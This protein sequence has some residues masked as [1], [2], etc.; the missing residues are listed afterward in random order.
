MRN[1]LLICFLLFLTL[2]FSQSE[3]EVINQIDSIN[4]AALNFYNVNDIMHSIDSF[5]EAIKLSDSINDSY[6]NAVANFTLGKIY[7][8]MEEYNDAESC[9]K[10][11]LAESQ[12][13]DD[14]F[15]IA[16][17]YLSLGEVYRNKQQISNV[18]PYFKNALLYA[19]KDIVTDQNNIDERHNVLFNIR[20]SL[21]K[22]YLDME[23][24]A[25]A[26]LYLLRARKNLDN[27][28][29]NVYNEGL[30]GYMFGRYFM[31]KNYYSMPMKSLMKPKPS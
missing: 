8:Y 14:N 17:S 1:N 24:P 15:L 26:L 7:S 20:M 10:K 30:L 29:Y 11:M 4:K 6:G 12:Q 28:P 25:E 16:Y 18:I 31:Q 3:R 23:D 19:Q 21:C 22:A 5:N 13:I 2:G 9:F 27:A